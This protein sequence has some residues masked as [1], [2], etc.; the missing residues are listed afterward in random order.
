MPASE[1]PYQPSPWPVAGH[2]FTGPDYATYREHGTTDCLLIY[3]AAG[4]GR[5]GAADGRAFLS[6][7]GDLIL[8]RPG[9]THDYATPAGG[10]WELLWTHFVARSDWLDLFDWPNEGPGLLRLGGAEIVRPELERVL[11]ATL[12][13]DPHAGRRAMNA[14]EAVLLSAAQ[15]NPR[16]STALEPRVRA[17]IDHI[18]ANLASPMTVD[19]LADVAGVSASRLAHLFRQSTG[20]A[21]MQYV[22]GRRIERAGQLLRLTP[23]SVKQVAA[24]VGFASP[25]YFSLRFKA[26]TGQSPS[27]YRANG[28]SHL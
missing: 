28:E 24:E 14:I 20:L 21:V 11:S 1:T 18:A 15:I 6:S 27:A 26:A 25:F 13:D 3:T 19:A 9:T 4:G 10:R 2:F 12:A 5:F 8:L 16:R 22:E 17:V 23:L 7:P